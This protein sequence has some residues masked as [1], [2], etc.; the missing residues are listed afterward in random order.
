MVAQDSALISF[1]SGGVG[2]IAA[3]AVGHPFD[4]VKVRLQTSTA[5]SMNGSVFR[6][7][8][9]TVASEGIPGLYRGVSAPLLAVSPI[10]AIS[11]WGY[12]I[13]QRLTKM[14]RKDGDESPMSLIEISCAGGISALPTTVVMAPTERLKCLLQTSGTKYLG[15]L[16]C[17]RQV[18]SV[19][20]VASLYKGTV[21]TLARDIPGSIAWFGTYEIMKRELAKLQG[22]EDPSKLS[23]IAIMVA[24]GFAG[25]A[26]WGVCIPPDTLKSRFQ[27]SHEGQYKGVVDVYR[28]IVRE[29]GHGGLLKGF[30]PAMPKTLLIT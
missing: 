18:Y 14:M 20:G 10:Y 22:V 6:I 24:G 16:D 13:G 17:A 11:F 4:L 3:V 7:M 12:D 9:R 5:E 26:C 25:M 1:L 23:S 19:G 29:E 2:G 28:H 15:L 27:T 8:Q 21:L 30:R